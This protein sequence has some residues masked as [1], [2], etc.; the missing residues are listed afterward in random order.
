MSI[1]LAVVVLVG[2]IYFLS[3]TDSL[4]EEVRALKAEQAKQP[5]LRVHVTQWIL[6]WAREGR[7]PP[8]ALRKFAGCGKNI[9]GLDV[10]ADDGE[11]T[12]PE[13]AAL[14]AEAAKVAAV[15]EAMPR[16]PDA[17]TT[18]HITTF[19]LE[20]LSKGAIPSA[21]TMNLAWCGAVLTARD[22]LGEGL[23]KPT[24]PKCAALLEGAT[25]AR[26]AHGREPQT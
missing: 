1:F 25:R 12:C 24:C 5:K 22:V 26:P 3:R 19:V 11:A 13:C 17:P 6:Q 9:G 21:G 8:A 23:E 10:L 18:V 7:S 4:K 16:D 2:V 20:V 14:W 15:R